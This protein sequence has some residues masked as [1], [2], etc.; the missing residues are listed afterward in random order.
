MYQTIFD[1][2]TLIEI[3]LVSIIFENCIS[4]ILMIFGKA[5]NF[6]ITDNSY[7]E[8]FYFAAFTSLA[9]NY[10]VYRR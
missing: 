9:G 4:Q 7:V 2:Q 1:I 8:N 5:G 10:L 3:I 6:T